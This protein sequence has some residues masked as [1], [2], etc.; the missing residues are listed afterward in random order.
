[1]CAEW[2]T[3]PQSWIAR[4]E[5]SKKRRPVAGV[6]LDH[7]GPG[8]RTVGYRHRRSDLESGGAA[9]R[10]TGGQR[11]GRSLVSADSTDLTKRA[12]QPP[13]G[14]G[15]PASVEHQQIVE[16]HAVARGVDAGVDDVR[17]RRG[18]A[19]RRCG[20]TSPLGRG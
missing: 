1:M 16:R 10:L 11:R 20:R 7:R 19:Q 15:L 3:C 2:I 4:G 17:S 8:R 14:I 5:G 6:D 9:L 13:V 12:A 18:E